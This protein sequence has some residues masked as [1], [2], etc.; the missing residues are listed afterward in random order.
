MADVEKT[1]RSGEGHDHAHHGGLPEHLEEMNRVHTNIDVIETTTENPYFEI[2]FIGTYAAITL[3]TCAAFAGFVMP[4]TALTLI[5]AA[6][7]E[8]KVHMAVW[9]V[10]H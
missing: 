1:A 2:N 5:N 6:V 8:E 9:R 3:A 10:I 7:G 4:V